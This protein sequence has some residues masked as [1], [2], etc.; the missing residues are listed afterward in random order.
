VTKTRGDRLL[1]ARLF[2]RRAK[3]SPSPPDP[4]DPGSDCGS[5]STGTALPRWPSKPA[6]AEFWRSSLRHQ[7]ETATS[8]TFLPQSSARMWRAAWNP[9]R[10]GSPMSS[11]SACWQEVLGEVQRFESVVRRSHVASQKPQQHPHA[12]GSAFV[13]VHDE[14]AVRRAKGLGECPTDQARLRSISFG[15]LHSCSVGS[16]LLTLFRRH[17]ARLQCVLKSEW[18]PG[19]AAAQRDRA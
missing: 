4:T 3:Q 16:L 7:P 12:F 10:L 17:T 1:R 11:T 8:T 6:S 18:C 13:V 14:D 9:S 2:E 15:L 19:R 5:D